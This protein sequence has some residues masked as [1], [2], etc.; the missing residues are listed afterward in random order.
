[1]ADALVGLDTAN[2]STK[3]RVEQ[4]MTGHAM[5]QNPKWDDVGTGPSEVSAEAAI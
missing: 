4:Q 2:S 3:V 1:M 5:Q